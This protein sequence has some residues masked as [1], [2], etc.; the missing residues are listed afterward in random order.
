MRT[1]ES[2]LYI[3]LN[4]FYRDSRDLFS[5]NDENTISKQHE[6]SDEYVDRVIA[7]FWK[8]GLLAQRVIP[9]ENLIPKEEEDE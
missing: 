1:L 9:K 4:D 2:E 8:R 6:R 3:L 5:S 7:A